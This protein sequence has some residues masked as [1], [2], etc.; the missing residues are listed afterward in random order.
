MASSQRARMLEAMGHVVA[1]RGIKAAT[2]ADVIAQAGVSRRTFYEHFQDLEACF[3]ATYEDGMQKLFGAIRETLRKAPGSDWR[4]RT[5]LAIRAYLKALAEA[6]QLSWSFSIESLG[7]GTR[8]LEQRAWVLDQWVAQWR[9]LQALRERA[10]PR[11]PR[12]ADATLL[13]MV[14]G[15]EELVRDCLRKRGAKALPRMAPSVTEF[16]LAVLGSRKISGGG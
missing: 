14:G 16:A 5:R 13:G 3:L 2:V 4:E 15:I 9:A 6:P 10:D 7:A 1:A 8:A 11:T 12:V